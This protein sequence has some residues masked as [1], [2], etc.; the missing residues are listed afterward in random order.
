[1]TT[2]EVKENVIEVKQ[3]IRFT[4]SFGRHKKYYIW[5]ISR[6]P[7]K[8]SCRCLWVWKTFNMTTIRNYYDLY[9]KT[10]VILVADIFVN[11]RDICLKNK[12]DSAWYYTAPRLAWDA[13]LKL[14]IKINFRSWYA[15]YDWKIYSWWCFLWF[16]NDKEKPTTHTWN[17]M[18]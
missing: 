8:I 2:I 7:N 6:P 3:V 18:I 13:A 12:L 4:E 17:N 11:F 10:D 9:L 1:M 15:T 14:K 16:L 5:K